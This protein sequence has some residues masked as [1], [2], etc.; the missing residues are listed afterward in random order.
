[1]KL[2][3]D[4]CTLIWLTSDPAQLSQH[5]S[6]QLADTENDLF[7]SDISVLEI[8]LKYTRDKIKLP[9][10]PRDWVEN[11]IRQW[12]I[13]TVALDRGVIYRTTELPLHHA[14]PFDRLLVATCLE[15]SMHIVTPDVH[16][17]RYPVSWSW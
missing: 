2:L 15:H 8:A 4:T 11:Q 13:G 1:V 3:L 14:D 9:T 5:A 12:E 10:P 16:I 6:R 7:L 17:H